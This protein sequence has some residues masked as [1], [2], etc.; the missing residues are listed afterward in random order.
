MDKIWI[1]WSDKTW[2]W[3]FVPHPCPI[4]CLVIFDYNWE[5]WLK[6][7]ML[8]NF[9]A[10]F[11]QSPNNLTKNFTKHLLKSCLVLRLKLYLFGTFVSTYYIWNHAELWY[12]YKNAMIVHPNV[13]TV[14]NACLKSLAAIFRL[15]FFK[16]LRL[17]R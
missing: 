4:F 16:F 5:T 9:Q 17:R 15:P 12:A 1:N 6:L 3:G 7:V 8:E 11:L 10:C 14:V 2:G 13:C